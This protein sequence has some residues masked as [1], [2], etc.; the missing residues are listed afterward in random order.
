MRKIIISS[1]LAVSLA[2]CITS[3]KLQEPAR[4]QFYV[5]CLM[6][7]I[8]VSAC[9]CIENKTVQQTKI[10]N[11]SDT[12]EGTIFL[13]EAQKHI[14]DCNKQVETDSKE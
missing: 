7:G 8:T 6:N 13:T 9:E 2:G 3:K 11:P 5:L 1:L 4:S 14:E 12:D 10:T